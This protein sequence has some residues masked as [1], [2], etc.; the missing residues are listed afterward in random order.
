MMF[1]GWPFNQVRAHVD[2]Q[3]YID[4]WI[5]GYLAKNTDTL[6][7]SISERRLWWAVAR[8]ESHNTDGLPH[9]KISIR[10]EPHWMKRC[11]RMNGWKAPSNLPSRLTAAVPRYKWNTHRWKNNYKYLRLAKKYGW[12]ASEAAHCATSFGKYQIMGMH[13]VL[14]GF[15]T[16]KEMA[17]Q[18]HVHP[19]DDFN[20]MMFMRFLKDYR[21]GECYRDL[22]GYRFNAFAEC[23]NGHIRYAKKLRANYQLAK[24][25]VN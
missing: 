24:I 21:G 23:Y 7:G 4:G 16:A 6:K 15:K 12:K 9:G 22:M 20:F 14:L 5:D 17:D 18:Y 11:Y 10:Y 2:P 8:T 1:T 3:T 25:K 13:H 19:T